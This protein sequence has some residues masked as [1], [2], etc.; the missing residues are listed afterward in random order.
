[1]N[2]DFRSI[3]A[4]EARP[5]ASPESAPAKTSDRPDDSLPA[6]PSYD[7]LL[8]CLISVTSYHDRAASENEL[9][10]GLPL[11]ENADPSCYEVFYIYPN[12]IFGPAPNFGALA[13]PPQRRR[14]VRIVADSPLPATKKGR[15]PAV[16][17]Q[18]P[19]LSCEAEAQR[20]CLRWSF[21]L[22][23]AALPSRPRR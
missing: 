10:A 15:R 8:R 18:R 17:G 9:T 12:L 1:M 11:R 7:P 22:I 3:R 13:P 20:A 23:R 16:A 6:G 5:V 4:T 14:E 19:L 2:Q 21:S